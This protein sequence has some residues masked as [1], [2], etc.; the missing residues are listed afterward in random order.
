[1]RD[2]LPPY[3]VEC[4]MVSGFDDID[5]IVEMNTSDGPKNSITIIESYIDKRKS[6]LPNCMGP[7][8]LPHLPFEFP[9]GHHIRIQKFI[10]EIKN[11]YRKRKIESLPAL[12]EPPLASKHKSKKRKLEADKSDDSDSNI[13]STTNEIRRK[14]NN[15]SK[16]NYAGNVRENEHYTINVSRNPIDS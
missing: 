4:F 11:K 16:T 3:V 7:K 12:R 6:D 9:P 13:P 1:M 10:T 2:K 8:H 14:L 5:A 15:W